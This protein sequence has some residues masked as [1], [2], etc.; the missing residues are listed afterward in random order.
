LDIPKTLEILETLGVA[1]VGYKTDKFPEFFFSEG[2]CKAS[3]RVG[4]FVSVEKSVN[5]IVIESPEE[6][7]GLI[8]KSFVD[9][10]LKNGVIVGV[11]V[12]KEYEA[13]PVEVTRCIEV[14]LK[15]A[16]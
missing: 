2:S 15:E 11:P 7:A 4:K 16:V 5:E 14:A 6:C 1:V 10:G 13:D 12:P 9:L 8:K 3:T